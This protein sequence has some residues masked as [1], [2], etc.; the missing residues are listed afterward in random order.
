MNE[1][2]PVSG[3]IYVH[4][5]YCRHRCHYC[6]FALVTPSVIPQ[7]AYTRAVIQEL[8]LRSGALPGPANTLYF[9]GGTPSLWGPE[10]VRSVIDAARQHHGLAMD[11]EITLEANPEDIEGALVERYAASGVNR[12]SL[13]VQSLLDER[14]AHLDR[15]HDAR[16]AEDAILA[17]RR[18][19]VPEISIDLIFGTPGQTEES[20]TGELEHALSLGVDH[21]SVYALTVEPRTRL[22][23]LIE[24]GSYGVVDEDVSAGLFDRTREVL[25]GA[26]WSHYEVSTYA[27][28]GHE[29]VHNRAYWHGQPYL[30]VG[31]A[32]HGLLH[33]R[34]WMNHR[35]PSRYI[36]ETS[37]GQPEES[38]ESIA[39]DVWAWERVLTGLR[40]LERG[41]EVAWLRSA[42]GDVFESLVRDGRLEEVGSRCRVHRDHVL[43]LDSILLELA[44]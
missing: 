21:L 31:A 38:S 34:R 33:Q 40:D 12:V 9:G 3:G 8:S 2:E 42:T 39:D 32:A 1:P 29:A 43:F 17:V 30:G 15:G 25:E 16:G 14:L 28:P 5:P 27:R 35:R 13:G 41:V 26:G 37:G 22:A 36:E 10:H 44:P 19:G 20:W 6:D 4:F 7:E 18:A 24:D 11:A 23:S